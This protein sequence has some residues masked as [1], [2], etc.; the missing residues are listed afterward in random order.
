M[1]NNE[2][3]L[4]VTAV[5]AEK[6][7]IL[8]GIGHNDKIDVLE[9]GVGPIEAAVRTTVALSKNKYDLVISAGI[10]GAFPT[11]ATIG[12]IVVADH[13]EVA[14]LGAE[15]PNGFLSVDELGFGTATY[16][17]NQSAV[18]EIYQFLH[19]S[20]QLVVKGTVITVSTVTGTKEKAQELTKRIE[21]VTAEA[22][23][24]FGV[25]TAAKQFDTPALELRSISNMVGPRNKEEWN[26]KGALQGLEMAFSHLK[27]VLT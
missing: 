4:I 6:E 2:K 5:A 21:N 7:A 23:E 17:V 1:I 14:D 11:K 27:E 25:A 24:G 19:K 22:M 16:N 10:G 18:D 13:L 3:I 9:V 20:N 12:S 15:T 26:I 8:R